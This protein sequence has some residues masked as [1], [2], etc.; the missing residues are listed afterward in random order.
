MP[1]SICLSGLEGS[2]P[3][4][5]VQSLREYPKAEPAKIAILK[6][7]LSPFAI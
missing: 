1:W 2:G 7:L 4:T 6:K 5:S 3:V